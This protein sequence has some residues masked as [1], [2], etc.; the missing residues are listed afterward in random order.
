MGALGTAPGFGALV[1]NFK[2][3][4][5]FVNW[6]SFSTSEGTEESAEE[7]L[8]DILVVVVVSRIVG[9]VGGRGQGNM[10]QVKGSRFKG[11]GK[12]VK[13]VQ[14]DRFYWV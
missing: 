2:M 7:S 3:P 14:A 12:A 9:G 5:F 11:D 13:W 1:K 10:S 8:S 6:R 4:F